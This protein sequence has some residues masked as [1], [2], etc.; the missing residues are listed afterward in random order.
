MIDPSE[1]NPPFYAS[2]KEISSIPAPM[3]A[4]E[5]T[6]Q[7]EENVEVEFYRS[8][9]EINSM[10]APMTTS[11]VEENV[12]VEKNYFG[13][14]IN[15]VLSATWLLLFSNI[16]AFQL[17]N[18]NWDI[19]GIN[20]RLNI[21]GR[22]ILA[23]AALLLGSF[24][25]YIL[26][27]N[28]EM[29]I[30]KKDSDLVS[31]LTSAWPLVLGTILYF[32]IACFVYKNHAWKRINYFIDKNEP[33]CFSSQNLIIFLVSLSIPVS[34]CGFFLFGDF[35]SSIFSPWT[36]KDESQTAIEAEES[37]SECRIF[38]FIWFIGFAAIW[39]CWAFM[40][41]SDILFKKYEKLAELLFFIVI[42]I[43]SFVNFGVLFY[44]L[45]TPK[46]DSGDSSNWIE[47]FKKNWVIISS[48]LILSC[49]A[50]CAFPKLSSSTFCIILPSICT[51]LILIPSNS[52]QSCVRHF[53]PWN[54]VK[55]FDQIQV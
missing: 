39:L 43:F 49:D 5:D 31:K 9:K 2:E 48:C 52:S 10:L 8:E 22:F 38:G 12:E 55:K 54:S 51:V 3:K 7:V 24:H 46:Y 40:I 21:I 11:Q 47:F 20:N 15:A 41:G 25:A 23:L 29:K 33:Y 27:D 26:F 16:L 30:K 17:M 36:V 35:S 37:A 6:P 14:F 28:Q 13:Y 19:F 18:F 53:K 4:T 45:S 34:F 1:Q 44:T 42:S 32:I 50:L